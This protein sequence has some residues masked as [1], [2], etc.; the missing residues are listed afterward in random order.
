MRCAF[1][2]TN[3]PQR[4]AWCNL[5]AIDWHKACPIPAAANNAVSLSTKCAAE[6]AGNC[7]QI[8]NNL[9]A[10][11]ETF[12]SLSV[13]DATTGADAHTATFSLVRE[14]TPS[15]ETRWGLM[16]RAALSDEDAAGVLTGNITTN[17][18]S[19][20][21]YGV[22]A[23]GEGLYLDGFMMV[24]RSRQSLGGAIHLAARAVRHGCAG[25]DWGGEL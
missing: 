25:T 8:R 22:T 16:L 11:G 9:F 21:L 10:S 6:D 12:A 24:G 23:L 4:A 18:G 13:K 5:R 15:P 14:F 7:S 19:I 3:K 20:G 1:F 17:A 2:R